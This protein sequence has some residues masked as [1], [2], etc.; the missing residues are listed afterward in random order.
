MQSLQ[1]AH[2]SEATKLA[3]AAFADR[4]IHTCQAN[5][6]DN[7]NYASLLPEFFEIC[8][9]FIDEIQRDVRNSLILALIYFCFYFYILF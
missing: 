5:N 1:S 3:I 6:N 9:D 8:N 7:N 4:F 2:R